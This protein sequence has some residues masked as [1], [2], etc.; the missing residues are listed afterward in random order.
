MG[1]RIL[2]L[3]S[4]QSKENG[5]RMSALLSCLFFLAIAYSSYQ[6]AKRQGLWSWKEFLIV[7]VSLV[8]VPVLI[9]LAVFNMPWFKD[10]PLLATGIVLTLIILFVCALGYVLAKYFPTAKK[11]KP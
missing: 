9:V 7:I 1:A 2:R 8:A 6:T 11:S 10:K 4:R 3:K 5:R